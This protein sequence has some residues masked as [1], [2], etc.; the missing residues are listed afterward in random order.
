MFS[1][2]L[3]SIATKIRLQDGFDEHGDSSVVASQNINRLH[4]NTSR[5]IS[6]QEEMLLQVVWGYFALIWT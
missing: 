1:C 6:Q 5:D 2:V 3:P 4:G